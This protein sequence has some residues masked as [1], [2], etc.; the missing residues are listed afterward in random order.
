MKL[1]NITITKRK[2][3]TKSI[4]AYNLPEERAERECEQWGWMYDDGKDSYYMGY[5]ESSVTSEV[6]E[7]LENSFL[8]DLFDAL[9]VETDAD[10]LEAIREEISKRTIKTNIG[11]MPVVDYLDIHAMQCGFDSYEDL[12]KQGYNIDID[13]L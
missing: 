10:L 13:K 6:L 11:T 8:A 9:E 4:L 5:E 3:G 1:Y 7:V 2:D 12:K